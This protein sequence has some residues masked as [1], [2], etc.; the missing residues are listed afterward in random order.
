M[1]CGS[2]LASTVVLDIGSGLNTI[3]YLDTI[4]SNVMVGNR[5]FVNP[6]GRL[7]NPGETQPYPIPP[8]PDPTNNREPTFDL[9][10]IRV[11]ETVLPFGKGKADRLFPFFHKDGEGNT[12]FTWK[13]SGL[14]IEVWD[15][16][17]ACY[18]Y[19]RNPDINY[20]EG[21]TIT[22]DAYDKSSGNVQYAYYNW[23]LGKNVI[24]PGSSGMVKVSCDDKF[25][26]LE[27][28]FIDHVGKDLE[29]DAKEDT[30]KQSEGDYIPPK[31]LYNIGK[32]LSEPSQDLAI[33]VE[34]LNKGTPYESLIL[35][36][37]SSKIHITP[38]SDEEEEDRISKTFA[39]V[40]EE[41]KWRFMEIRE[42][43]E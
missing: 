9:I 40:L 14:D 25:G 32:P 11:T 33:T 28:Q 29:A 10:P 36:I 19:T 37:D 6:F 22:L 42:C 18:P 20:A 24:L 41:E 7:G 5:L 35:Y 23:I 21:L 13:S 38:E 27:D 31:N 3:A 26:Y 15:T 8:Y 43:E 34:T 30:A 12:I 17:G 4:P 16:E 1:T 39:L 2:S